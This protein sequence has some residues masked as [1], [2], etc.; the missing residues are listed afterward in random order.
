MAIVKVGVMTDPPAEADYTNLIGHLQD[1]INQGNGV[2]NILYQVGNG[3]PVIK[4]GTYISFGGVLYIFLRGMSQNQDDSSKHQGVYY[5]RPT[6]QEVQSYE[7]PKKY[8]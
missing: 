2:K 6:W 1:L 5:K 3:L 7:L 4:Q 8:K